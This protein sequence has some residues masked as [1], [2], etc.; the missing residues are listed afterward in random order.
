MASH[1]A[2]L[3]GVN[4]GRH[5]RVSSEELRAAFEALGLEGSST[6]RTSGNVAFTAA[7]ERPAALTRR[8]EEGL[9][10]ALGY[11]VST[12]VRDA[13]EMREI[14]AAQPFPARLVE[15]SS[16]KLQVSLLAEKPSASMRRQVL[17]MAGEED[18]LAFGKRELYWLPSGGTLETALDLA[19]LERLLGATTRRTMG[20]IEQMA[21]KHFAG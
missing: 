10:R 11:P 2:F 8:I 14:A 20:T 13:R 18:L 16:G 3:R 21:A 19:A 4:V 7:G 9:Q 12:F 15:A 1:A 17:A 6:F 5:H